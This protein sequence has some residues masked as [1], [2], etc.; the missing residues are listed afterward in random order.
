MTL[1]HEC[2]IMYLTSRVSHLIDVCDITHS[3]RCCHKTNTYIYIYI[4]ICIHI[5]LHTH[6]GIRLPYIYIYIPT[7]IDIYIHTHRF[8]IAIYLHIHTYIYTH[9]HTHTQ[10]LDCRN[11]AMLSWVQEAL[12]SKQHGVANMDMTLLRQ[13]YQFLLWKHLWKEAFRPLSRCSLPPP[14]PS[15][16]SCRDVEDTLLGGVGGWEGYVTQK[17]RQGGVPVATSGLQLQVARCVQ[18]LGLG[19]EVE[20]L[21]VHTGY[22]VDLA[23]RF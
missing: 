1:I 19:V 10:V 11:E 23:G 8:Q 18:S 16:S 12:Q 22:S 6:T 13:V 7:Y 21:E 4:S 3:Q 14:P 5:Y 2:D 15:N 20:H 17:V 9:I